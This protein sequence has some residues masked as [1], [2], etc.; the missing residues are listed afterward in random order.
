MANTPNNRHY[1][2]IKD[3]PLSQLSVKEKNALIKGLLDEKNELL[4]KVQALESNCK[5]AYEQVRVTKEHYD[6]LVVQ[7]NNDI[8]Y[9]NK[10]T[11]VFAES[12]YRATK[13]DTNDSL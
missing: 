6:K 3:L 13:G 7:I 2:T 4:G 9:I 12:I 11:A 8:A 5:S 1:A 10:T